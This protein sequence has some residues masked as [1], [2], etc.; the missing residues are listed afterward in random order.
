MDTDGHE[1]KFDIYQGTGI[2]NYFKSHISPCPHL[3]QE[4]G[5]ISAL[6]FTLSDVTSFLPGNLSELT[7]II[8]RSEALIRV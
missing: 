5:L 6:K 1:L 8:S 2:T 7:K 4:K 3:F